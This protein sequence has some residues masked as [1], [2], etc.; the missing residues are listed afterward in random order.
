MTTLISIS[1]TALIPQHYYYSTKTTALIL[2]QQYDS[3]ELKWEGE[4]DKN[5]LKQLEGQCS[6]TWWQR[7]LI[8]KAC[9]SH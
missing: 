8:S 6:E 3:T 1:V 5:D 9:G 7:G 2:Q 4:A